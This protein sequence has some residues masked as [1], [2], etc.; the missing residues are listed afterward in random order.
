MT[1]STA[2]R[3]ESRSGRPNHGTQKRLPIAFLFLAF[4]LSCC[5]GKPQH[6]ARAPHIENALAAHELSDFTGVIDTLTVP[7]LFQRFGNPLAD[8][9]SG[10]HVY[11][12]LL[13]DGSA[14]L[15]GS[16]DGRTIFY[17]RHRETFLKPP[18]QAK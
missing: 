12:Y 1:T 2:A 18:P 17:A 15:V 8:V 13:T 9:G 5:S 3:S 7:G 10:L 4:A 14:V 16:A 11:Q 6:Q